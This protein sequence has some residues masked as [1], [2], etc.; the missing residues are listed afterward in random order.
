MSVKFPCANAPAAAI[1]G[2]QFPVQPL[3]LGQFETPGVSRSN[4]YRV[5]A[6]GD[7][8]QAEAAL[9]VACC[10][11]LASGNRVGVGIGFGLGLP[12]EVLPPPPHPA[13][14]NSNAPAIP[15]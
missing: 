8:T 13:K 2:G 4:V 15:G 7:V 1:S 5:I 11:M 3:V 9:T 6:A 10:G 14:A 12:A